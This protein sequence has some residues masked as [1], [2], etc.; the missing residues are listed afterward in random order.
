[1]RA[2][3][4][5]SMSDEEIAIETTLM[6]MRE[7]IME[8]FKGTCVKRVT[9]NSNVKLTS[10]ERNG[11]YLYN[12][13]AEESANAK[14]LLLGDVPIMT[15]RLNPHVATIHTKPLQRSKQLRQIKELLEKF[16]DEY[17]PGIERRENNAN[18][19]TTVNI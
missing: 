15:M 19:V 4:T 7:Q 14:V 17:L 18:I 13:I 11:G 16:F 9:K 8:F 5:S 2:T 6:A 10:C 3:K 12:R 1:M